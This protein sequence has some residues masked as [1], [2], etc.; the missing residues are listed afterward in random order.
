MTKVVSLPDEA[1][2]L[3]RMFGIMDDFTTDLDSTKWT[4]TASNSGT[5]VVGD[6][7]GGV[8]TLNPSD[9]T[10]ANNDETYLLSANE[11]FKF[12]NDKPIWAEARI[13]F[14]E[15]AT[16]DVNIAFG[17]MNAVAANSILDDGGGPAA[18][19][20]GAVFY[21][22]DGGTVWNCENSV[23]ATQ[24]TTATTTTAGGASYQTLR[25]EVR[26]QAAGFFD[27]I[28]LVDGVEVAKHKDQALGSPTEMNLFVGIKN[29]ADTT[30]EALLVDYICA[31]QLR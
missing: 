20:S 3:P 16:D 17:L 1:L 28:F 25:I 6:S 29:G 19:Y 13:Q 7:V 5:I 10:V 11:S 9:E 4:T 30:A 21:K 18:S 2:L 31:Y 23:G 8:A 14:T 15:G 26:P 27:V 24:K 22:V 12:A